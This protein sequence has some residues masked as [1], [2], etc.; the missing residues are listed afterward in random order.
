VWRLAARVTDFVAR[1]GGD[2]FALLLPD[3][4]HEHAVAVVSRLRNAL[5]AGLTCSAGLA[6]WDGRMTADELVGAADAALYEAKNCGR[7]QIVS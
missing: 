4:T 6:R 7:D 5:P 3:C 2:E 1:Y